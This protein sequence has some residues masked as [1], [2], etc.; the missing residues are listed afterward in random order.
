MDDQLLFEEF[1]AAYDFEPRA[2]S[3]ERLRAA[4]M[5]ASVR[6]QRRF[7][8]DWPLPRISL[9]L[10]AALV[11]VVVVV[12]AVGGFLVVHN[13]LR[14]LVPAGSRGTIVIG[15][16]DTSG[17]P[18]TENIGQPIQLGEAFAITRAGSVRGYALK[19]VTYDDTVHGARDADLGIANVQKM[20]ANPR[21][22]G[23]IGPY[24]AAVAEAET[25]VASPASLAMISPVNTYTCL[26]VGN[27][28]VPQG[29]PAMD[30]YFR[31]AA[32]DD[33]SGPA[34]ADFA[35]DRLG[36]R[37]IAAWDDEDPSSLS[38]VDGFAAE[39]QRKGGR[40]V[41]RHDYVVCGT[42]D[43][44]VP[45]GSIGAP[46]FRPW[47]RQAKAAGAE[48]IYA[49]ADGYA[50][51]ARGQ[52]EG[53]FD[54]SSYYLGAGNLQEVG[55]VADGMADDRCAGDAGSMANDRIYATVGV[56]AAQLN[57][58][59]QSVIA[60]YKAAHPDPALTSFG[61][62]AGYDSAMILIDAIGRAIDA[63]GGRMPTRQQVLEQVAQ[64]K[65]FHGLTGT[66]TFDAAGDPLMPTIQVD[67]IVGGAWTP[68]A[69]LVIQNSTAA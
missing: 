23:M 68:I 4:V 58:K 46:D 52:S 36:L 43:Q 31:I 13:F 55:D 47:L 25:Y 11:A 62:F 42:A 2:G 27:P 41:S 1:H 63:N 21:L 5:S 18:G 17:G 6:P 65:N 28:C 38:A 49:A 3:F 33:L 19:F 29:R 15:S 66:F 22:L 51:V 61:T 32:L 45:G 26:T 64:T 10:I 59:A 20:I 39:F 7:A 14:P 30:S 67:H 69:N 44:C 48:A 34:M 56:G 24:D 35:Y 54:S 60:A 57:P 50:C 8:I 12:A 9:A 40:L 37:A 53:I 16:D